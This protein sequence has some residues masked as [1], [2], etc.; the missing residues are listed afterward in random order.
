MNPF[1]NRPSLK[2]YNEFL[3]NEKIGWLTS[4]QRDTVN[5]IVL[6]IKYQLAVPLT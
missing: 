3:T 4:E 1:I 2:V 6:T 5:E